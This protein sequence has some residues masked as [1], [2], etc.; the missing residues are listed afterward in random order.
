MSDQFIADPP[1]LRAEGNSILDK[2]Q[3]FGQNVE[4]IYST[5]EE[6]VSSSYVSPGARAIAAQI[7]TYRDDLNK[8]TR[9]IGDYGNYCITASNTVERNEQNIAD[10]ASGNTTCN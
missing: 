9:V 2:A 1:V 8:M 3:Q 7:Q 10:N 4:K 5:I 6:M